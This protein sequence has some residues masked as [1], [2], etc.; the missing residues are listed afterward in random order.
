MA[1]GVDPARVDCSNPDVECLM[2]NFEKIMAERDDQIAS[3][4]RLTIDWRPKKSGWRPGTRNWRKD[5]P[6]LR[7]NTRLIEMYDKLLG[8][9]GSRAAGMMDPLYRTI[10]KDLNAARWV[11]GGAA[12]ARQTKMSMSVHATCEQRGVNFYRFVQEYLSG[13]AKT[14][15]PRAAPIQTPAAV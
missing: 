9:A 15:P 6:T 7:Q 11:N 8:G 2:K 3:L 5:A 4:V 12:G 10:M 14:I 1:P 13:R